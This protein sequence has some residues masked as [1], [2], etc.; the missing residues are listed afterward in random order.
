MEF[1]VRFHFTTEQRKKKRGLDC[2]D[3]SQEVGEVQ[4]CDGVS[5]VATHDVDVVGTVASEA[6]AR[7]DFLLIP[8]LSTSNGRQPTGKPR[9]VNT[10]MSQE[11]RING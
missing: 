2:I 4:F 3:A 6:M 10:R 5:S 1:L 9:G 11:F 7:C 8:V